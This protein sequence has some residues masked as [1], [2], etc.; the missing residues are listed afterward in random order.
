[1]WLRKAQQIDVG[2]HVVFKSKQSSVKGLNFGDLMFVTEVNRV[3]VGPP[4]CT[5]V[6]K[7]EFGHP[8]SGRNLY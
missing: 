1:M 7:D 3:S 8:I 5:Q 4:E 2:K 6:I